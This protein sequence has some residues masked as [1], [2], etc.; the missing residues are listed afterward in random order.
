M[1]KRLPIIT[2]NTYSKM[3]RLIKQIL[4]HCPLRVMELQLF[5][6]LL[7]LISIQENHNIYSHK[8]NLQ[9]LGLHQAISTGYCW[10]LQVQLMQAIS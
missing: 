9:R 4:K 1:L 2:T 8:Q 7:K 10:M 5:L 6:K 3:F